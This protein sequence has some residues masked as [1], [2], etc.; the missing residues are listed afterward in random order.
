M[1]NVERFKLQSPYLGGS[2]IGGVLDL[3]AQ[4]ETVKSQPNG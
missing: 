4:A 2:M 1:F 3:C